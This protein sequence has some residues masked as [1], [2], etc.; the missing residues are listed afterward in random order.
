M[1]RSV[2]VIA[3]GESADIFDKPEGQK[4][5]DSHD[6]IM[7]VNDW[8]AVTTDTAAPRFPKALLPHLSGTNCIQVLAGNQGMI[9]HREPDPLIG[10]FLRVPESFLGVMMGAIVP[11]CLSMHGSAEKE[12]SD[13]PFVISSDFTWTP[14]PGRGRGPIGSSNISYSGSA[15]FLAH[16]RSW[17][18][19]QEKISRGKFARLSSWRAPK[20]IWD[21]CSCDNQA[22]YWFHATQKDC[23]PD[24][25]GT[26]WNMHPSSAA[27]CVD[28]P[29]RDP[30]IKTG[31]VCWDTGDTGL[32][33]V[34]LAAA[35]YDTV[36]VVGIDF[37]E[38]GYY[39][40]PEASKDGQKVFEK[41]L[42][43]KMKKGNRKVVSEGIV[44]D[45]AN[46]WLA[47]HQAGSKIRIISKSKT[48]AN[49]FT[50]VAD[51]I[52]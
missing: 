42:H 18:D 51:T 3:R 46:F 39:R 20:K 41:A 10:G 48:L 11:C 45:F 44:R 28:S 36:T 43:G 14:H 13:G 2:L 50:G 5:L 34:V 38:A 26:Y 6:D 23:S 8:R 7:I 40:P 25:I 49:Y 4:L 24:A 27:F 9:E 29:Q 52:A 31:R 37:W 47:L 35:L 1:S 33:T 19:I 22:Y 16:H 30:V 21:K 17:D 12:R 15:S 32:R